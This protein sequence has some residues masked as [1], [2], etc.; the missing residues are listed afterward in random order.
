VVDPAGST[1]CI[2]FYED[3]DG[4]GFGTKGETQCLCQPKGAWKALVGGDCNDKDA[5]VFPT[6][7]ELCNQVDDN[8]NGSVDETGA[9]GCTPFL[10]DADGDGF[11]VNGL[12]MCLCEPTGVW[13]ATEAGDCNDADAELHP[14]AIEICDDVDNN[15]NGFKDEDC[16]KD[17]DGYCNADKTVNGNPDVC[18]LGGGDCV[19]Y[20]SSIHPNA[21]EACDGVDNDCNGEVDEGVKAPCGGCEPVCLMGAGPKDENT[22]QDNEENLDGAGFDENG[23]VIL[24]AS[25][26]KLHMIWIANSGQGS[27]SKLDTTTGNEVARYQLCNDPSRTAVDSQGNAWIAC[28]GDARVVK[29]AL[30]ENECIDKNGDGVIQTSKDINGNGVIDGAEML[31]KDQDECVLFAVQP[32]GSDGKARAM[33]VDKDDHGWVGMWNTK[34]LFK[35]HKDTGKVLKEFNLPNN[36][37]GMAIAKDGIIWIAGRGGARLLRVDPKTGEMTQF[38][39]DIG[40]LD[41]YGIAIDINGRVWIGNCCCSH[42]AYRF[43]PQ[44]HKW[45]AVSVKARPRGIAADNKGYIYVANDQANHVAKINVNTLKVEGWTDLGAGRFP[46]GMAVDF[47]GKV[48]A[49]NQQSSTATRIDPDTMEIM[50]EKPTGPSPY[51]Y[52]DMTGFA[53]KTV[54]APF[55]KYTHTF[56]GWEGGKTKWQ[57]VGFNATTPEGTWIKVRVRVYDDADKLDEAQWSPIWGPFPPELQPINLND[58]GQVIGKFLQVEVTLGSEKGAEQSPILKSLDIVASKFGL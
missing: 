41:P 30:S 3:V 14:N 48:W 33:G 2:A 46:V 54:V 47:D 25:S 56:Q 51:T 28:R 39:S 24:D 26:I 55:G 17:N 27:I 18:P 50:L 29:V 16:D 42:V 35:I 36:P 5:T 38:N 11:G 52:S 23:N 8:C 7:Q 37:Y 34:K 53:Q 49:I 13:K 22:F 31:G 9:T 15:C 40:C 20:D 32:N 19:D 1:G 10:K 44:T 45:D 6:A 12:A 57:Q 21:K 58:F 43:D 4:D